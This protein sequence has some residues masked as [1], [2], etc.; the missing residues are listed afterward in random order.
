M[1]SVQQV[2][3]CA[4]NV[5]FQQSRERNPHKAASD[6]L[7]L[8]TSLGIGITEPAMEFLRWYAIGWQ[9]GEHGMVMRPDGLCQAAWEGRNG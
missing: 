7:A 8:R 5:G 2:A 9:N 1:L 3:E 6:E 4:G